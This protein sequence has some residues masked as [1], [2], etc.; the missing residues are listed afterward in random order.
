MGFLSIDMSIDEWVTQK[1]LEQLDM[2]VDWDNIFRYGPEFMDEFLKAHCNPKDETLVGYPN[3]LVLHINVDAAAWKEAASIKSLAELRRKHPNLLATS[4]IKPKGLEDGPEPHEDMDLEDEEERAHEL[5]VRNTMKTVRERKRA[6]DVIAFGEV[7]GHTEADSSVNGGNDKGKE[8]EHEDEMEESQGDDDDGD[9]AP[10]PA[11][12]PT[13]A[14]DDFVIQW[15]QDEEEEARPAQRARIEA[16]PTPEPEPEPEEDEDG[17][18]DD[19]GDEGA[20]GDVVG[21]N[22]E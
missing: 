22:L 7:T 13:T 5:M 17:E 20:E 9:E 10:S 11:P 16:P 12:A 6:R 1:R 18:E 4:S 2:P 15:S 14:V 21:D 8:E 19:E 3:A